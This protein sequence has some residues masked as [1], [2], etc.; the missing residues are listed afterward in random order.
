MK[1]C[2]GVDYGTQSGRALLVEIGTGREVATAVKSYTHGVM[3]EYLP[4]GTTKLEPDWALQ[5]PGDYLE[6]LQ[7]TIPEVLAKSGVSADDVV[8]IGIDFTACTILPTRAD[9]TPLCFLDEFKHHPHSYVKL[10]KHHAAQDE[11]N[12][13]NSMAD[14]RG[15]P[16]LSLYGGKI[17]SEW[18]FPKVWQILNEAPEVYE[19]AD[20][21]LE[22]TDWVVSQLVGK[23]MRNSCTAGYK[24]IWH[25][26]N[27]YP[28]KEF[29]KSLDP[30]LENVVDE[31]LSREIYPIGTKA[32]EI[33][34]RAAKLTGLNVGTAVAVGNVDAHVSIPAVGITEPGKML[35]I[36]GTS[37]C[38][39]L[40]GET[41]EIVPGMCG[42]VED[43]VMPGYMGYEAGQSCV[44]DHFE[45]FIEN[46]VSSDLQEEARRA[47]I[48]IHELLT[49]KASK[50]AVGESGLIA[51]DWWNGNRSTLVDADLTGLMLGATLLTKS[52][53]MYRALIE[54]TAYGTRTIIEAFRE[55]G[56]PVTELYAAG[57]IAEKNSLMMQI[58]ADVCNMEIRIAASPQTP[59]FGSAMFG[60]VAA[61]VERGGF[62][63]ISEAAKAIGKV[64]E[65]YYKPIPANVA[66]Y[67]RLYAEYKQLY[68]YFGRGDNDV[69]KRLKQIRKDAL[70]NS[71]SARSNVL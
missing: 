25:K 39:I 46:C 19:A 34:E 20:S 51:L 11:A 17:S 23:E 15:E 49:D 43:G 40:L 7:V 26:Q 63:S 66:V 55:N 27:G 21:I 28:S 53:E 30:G 44:G 33:T 24:A 70:T 61:G 13:L 57:G 36:M 67:D 4:D 47:G 64:K 37:T 2:I 71:S 22:A 56:V 52:E 41:E 10:W 58:Y 38:H 8:G 14:Q 59:A 62:G 5:H 1:Y 6:V 18:M 29:L 31:K 3:D 42:V 45:W 65:H 50:L 48:G 12:R 16:F 35:M 69:M 54:A 9:G 60:A 68:H 32:G